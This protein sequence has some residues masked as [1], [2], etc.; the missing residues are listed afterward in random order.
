MAATRDQCAP[1]SG[2]FSGTPPGPPEK[3]RPMA[4][5]SPTPGLDQSQTPLGNAAD[6]RDHC[7]AVNTAGPYSRWK[8]AWLKGFKRHLK[9]FS[10]SGPP[11]TWRGDK[12]GFSGQFGS[13]S[14]SSTAKSAA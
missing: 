11:A 14:G 8:N 10:S 6:S 9:T 7:A 12:V 4:L 13:S 2:W 1:C 5:D 3:V